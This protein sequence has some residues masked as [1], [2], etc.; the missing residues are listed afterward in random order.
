[1]TTAVAIERSTPASAWRT[2]L[3]A[4]AGVAAAILLLFLP[5]VA[6]LAAIWWDSPTFNHCLLIPPIIGWL[7]WQRAPELARLTPAAWAPGLV[8]VA[9]G[10]ASWLA[11]EAGSVALPRQ[12]GLIL[13][14][15]G[16]VISCLGRDVARGLLFP[17]AYALFL[18]PLG[19]E[20][21]PAMQTLTAQMVTGLLGASGVPAHVEGVFITTPVGYFEVAEACAGVRFLVAMVAFGALVANVCFK[22]WPRRI[23]FLAACV[24]VPILANAVRAWGTITIAEQ[25]GSVDFAASFDHVLYGWFFFAL[26]IALIMGAG[27]RFF[28]RAVDEPWLANVEPS[29]RRGGSVSVVAGLIVAIA[30]LPVA[31]SQAVAFTGAQ[32][33]PA[34]IAMP[35]VPGWRQ[36]AASGGRPWQPHFAGADLIRMARYRDSA[37][38]EV[39]LAIA[40]FARQEEGRE[41]ADFGNG[42]AGPDSDWSWSADAPAPPGGRAERI[43]SHG[44]VREVLSFYRVGDM[45]TGS[46]TGVRLETMRVRLLGGPQR[47]VA[48]LIAAPEPAAGVSPRPALD[49]FLAALGPVDRLADRAAGLE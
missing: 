3:T 42:A 37:G 26:V 32:A 8:L 35:A 43:A 46:R 44:L 40:V 17:I 45:L 30:A 12:A 2:H 22:A 20:L 49:A 48:V 14:L 4:L 39:D 29:G 1:M 13:M 33:A 9:L 25:S 41:L 23:A 10:A 16:A 11:G 31:W 18:I 27:W 7:V 47:A 36:V 34:D 5:D 24:I 28:D 6:G 21:V 15:Q 38:R 19:A